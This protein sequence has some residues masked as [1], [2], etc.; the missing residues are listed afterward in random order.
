MSEIELK[1]Q[2]P[3]NY[4][5]AFEKAF[6]KNKLVQQQRL[7]AKYYDSPEQHL[8]K[9]R[10]ALRQRLEGDIWRQTLKAPSPQHYERF[11][12]EH[13]LGHDAPELCDLACYENHKQARKILKK[14]LDGSEVDLTL[15]FETDVLRYSQLAH[16]KNSQIE[17]AF[18]LGEI[19]Q[20]KNSVEIYEVEFELKH[21]E[22]AD[23]IAYIQPWIKKYHLWL[24]TRSK[25]QRGNMLYNNE[26]MIPVQQQNT[27]QLQ[28]PENMHEL[29]A[30]ITQNC[31]AHLLPNAAAIASQ[32]YASG[33]VHQAR[34][35]IRRLRSALKI[36]AEYDAQANN[37]WESQLANLFQQL[38]STRDQDALRESL[39]PQ[40]ENAGSPI[41]ELP[42]AASENIAIDTIFRSPTTT[43]LLLQLMSFAHSA[44]VADAESKSLKKVLR[45]RLQK[46]HQQI[47]DDAGH[48]QTLD[49]ESKH[50]TRKR[51]KRLRYTV[52]F[53]SSLFAE[54]EVKTYLKT[55]KPLQETLGHFNDL[56]VAQGL[57]ESH[58]QTEPKT[59]FVLGWIASEERHISIQIEQ[60]LQQFAV[61]Q[62]FWS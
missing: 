28:H 40:L 42:P 15:Q 21:G 20:G 44:A 38:G 25:S 6:K 19:R 7:W 30:Q 45:K 57:Y 49:V 46:M 27:L 11:E 23:L 59:W 18:D 41:T 62:P 43:L 24:D 10:I 3:H 9:Q 55:L 52:E 56:M 32:D 58:A 8:A 50:R 17:V 29:L 34:V 35:A 33:H 39:I 47:C 31:L 36:F 4:R 37:N 51:V 54:D 22:I 53:V 60:D 14:A 61:S 1:F 5:A 12:L 26:T 2:I 13:E 48:F 16:Y